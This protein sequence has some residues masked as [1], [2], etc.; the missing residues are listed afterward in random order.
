MIYK[1][2]PTIIKLIEQTKDYVQKNVE[3]E[4]VELI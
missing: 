2:S 4:C 3:D 1:K